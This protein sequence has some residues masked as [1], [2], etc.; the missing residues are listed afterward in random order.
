MNSNIAEKKDVT[1]RNV[2]AELYDNF[3]TFA[4][5][6][7]KSTGEFFDFL[8]ISLNEPHHSALRFMR[9]RPPTFHSN[10][11]VITGM[12]SLKV[13]RKDLEGAVGKRVYH[14][15][16]IGELEF[17][18]DVDGKLLSETVHAIRKCRSVKFKGNVPKLLRLGLVM[19]KPTYNY[20]T[21][22]SKLKDIT[23]RKVSKD[24][25]DSFLAKSKEES[26]TT[27]ELFSE[28]L[29][30]LMPSFDLFENI[31]IIERESKTFPLVITREDNLTV[32]NND[33]KEIA[34]K[35]VIFY[36]V[37][38]LEFDDSVEEETFD[39]FVAKIIKCKEVIIPKNI[40]RLLALARTTEGSKVVLGKETIR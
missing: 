29:A 13:S 36:N 2:D 6:E 35:K 11:E 16:R 17:E 18:E 12:R 21:D 4:R 24:I 1:I 20:P 14:F 32:T 15:C 22:P 33:L 9:R 3:A 8:F 23:I 40:P 37:K 7:G 30:F 19:K 26:K 25:Y 38:M 31:R 34:P 10:L 5:K 27:G 28:Y 39:K